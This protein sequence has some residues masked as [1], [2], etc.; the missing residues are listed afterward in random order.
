MCPFIAVNSSLL[1]VFIGARLE[2]KVKPTPSGTTAR[3]NITGTID[4]GISRA[5]NVTIIAVFLD[6]WRI[7]R[8]K[9]T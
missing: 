1:T 9:A 5:N 3:C 7:R 4:L 8:G 2:W 6:S